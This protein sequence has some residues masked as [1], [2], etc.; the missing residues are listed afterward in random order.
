M[1]DASKPCT[2]SN[3]FVNASAN[4]LNFFCRT[5]R[6][7]Y[8]DIECGIST[9]A[10]ISWVPS[11]APLPFLVCIVTVASIRSGTWPV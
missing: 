3:C 8:G 9:E 4:S 11:K 10:V 1:P 5:F 6:T 2:Q 7:S